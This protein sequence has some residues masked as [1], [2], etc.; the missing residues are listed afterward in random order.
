MPATRRSL[1]IGGAALLTS[2][3]VIRPGRAVESGNARAVDG[4]LRVALVI[5][6]GLTQLDAT[7]PYEVL[8]RTP[9]LSV[10]LVAKTMDPVR[11][12]PGMRILPEADFS[13]RD[14]YDILCVPG[15]GGVDP[16]ITD[17]E[18][19]DFIRDVAA[20]SRYVTGVCTGVLLLG[21]AGLLD[22]RKATT[23]WTTGHFLNEFGCEYVDERVVVDGNLITGAGV[24][25]G[26]DFGFALAE[27]IAG[28]DAAARAM[29]AM[30]YDPAPPFA[31]GRPENTAPAVVD[32][33]R[34]SIQGSQERR[35]AQIKRAVDTLSATRAAV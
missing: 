7:G 12:G 33:Y 19:L 25:S 5:F 11:T 27:L 21:A 26:I 20:R 1:L 10:T 17:P 30:E 18:T 2:S 28:R 35:R 32:A 6:P 14:D 9:G 22:G 31:G 8:T 3:A 4:P 29:L 24:S 15:G 16:L 13:S 23:H 34:A